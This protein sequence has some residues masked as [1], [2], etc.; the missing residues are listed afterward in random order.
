MS[1]IK[2]C[3]DALPQPCSCF[4]CE[5]YEILVALNFPSNLN[6]H[7]ISSGVVVEKN[8]MIINSIFEGRFQDIYIFAT[9][10]MCFHN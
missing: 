4:L 7:A 5:F 2:M 8:K 1:T 6:L 3:L 9:T 10:K